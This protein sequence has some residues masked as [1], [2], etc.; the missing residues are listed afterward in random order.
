MGY[1][2]GQVPGSCAI[3]RGTDA[4]GTER[5]RKRWMVVGVA[6][7]SDAGDGHGAVRLGYRCF[8]VDTSVS[9]NGLR[10]LTAIT[11]KRAMGARHEQRSEPG[12]VPWY[13]VA[14]AV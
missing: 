3:F 8:G 1:G 9:V 5:V 12:W 2:V 14:Y 10:A 13:W 11:T 4:R 7:G 6:L